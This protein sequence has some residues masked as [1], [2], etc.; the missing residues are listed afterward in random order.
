MNNYEKFIDDLKKEANNKEIADYSSVIKAQY[1]MN[2]TSS[3]KQNKA[4]FKW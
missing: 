3:L 4:F 1:K 2:H